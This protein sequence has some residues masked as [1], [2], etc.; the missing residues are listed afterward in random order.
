MTMILHGDILF[1]D[2]EALYGGA[3]SAFQGADYITSEEWLS[4]ESFNNPAAENF[5]WNVATNGGFT[6]SYRHDAN[7]I[8]I[9]DIIANHANIAAA[10][11]G[12]AF[13]RFDLSL[14]LWGW[15][16]FM[17]IEHK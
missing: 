12:R 3:L 8:S 16:T 17:E 13:D 1:V 9:L 6:E 15:S 4:P 2:N 14:I 7:I 11:Y 5:C 10:K